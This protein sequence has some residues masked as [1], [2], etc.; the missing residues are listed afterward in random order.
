MPDALV[1]GAAYSLTSYLSWVVLVRYCRFRNSLERIADVGGF[2]FFG[3]LLIPVVSSFLTT[4]AIWVFT[5]DFCPDFV[6]LYSVRWLSDA[7]GVMVIAPFLLVWYS[8]TRINWR[9]EQTLEVLIWLFVLIFLGA[10]VFRNWAPTDTLRYP[11]ELA[12]FPI[13]A[14]AAIRFGQRGVTL[15]ILLA[16]MMAVWELRDVIGP[17]A[18]KTISQPPGYL[19]VFV[20]VL[21]V[22]SLFLAATWTELRK[23]EDELRTNEERLRAFVHAMPD[24]ALVFQEDGTCS[25]IFAPINSHFRERI[26]SFKNEPLESIYPPDL[27]RKFRDTIQE[28]VQK[29]DLAIVRYAISVDGMDRIYEGRFAPIEAFGEQQ[30]AVMVVSYDLTDNQHARQDLQKRD[31]LLKT[32]TE[33]EGI[34]LKEKIFHRGVRRAIECIGKGV[35][36]DMVQVYRVHVPTGTNDIMECTHEWLREN[37]YMFG[38]TNISEESLAQVSPRWKEIFEEGKPWEMHYSEADES[39]RSFMNSLG[40]RSITLMGITPTGGELGFIIFGSSLERSGKD[41]HAFAVL[42]AITESLRAYMENQLNQEELNRT[43]EAAIAADHAK[44]EFLAIMSHEIRTPMNAIIGFSDLL[45]QT[46]MSEQQKEYVDIILRSGNDLLDLINNILDFSRLESNSI[47][48][49]RTRFSL[50][51]AI[52]E[53]MEMVLFKAK[54]KGIGLTYS[55]LGIEKSL[56]WG[57]P[58]RL[59]QILLNL[60]TNAVKFT[61]EGFVRLEVKIV[62]TEEPWYTLEFSVLDT[63]IGIPEEN[64]TELF[65]AFRQ[66]D[67]STTRE[68]GGTGLGLSIVQRL[69]DKMGGRVSME[70]TVG[71]GSTF[72]VVVRLERDMSDEKQVPA[73]RRKPALDKS[74]AGKHPLT[75][76][77]VEDD[78]VNTRL[79]CE[80]LERLGYPVEA[81]T[82][83]FKALAVLAE[84]RHNLVMMDMQMA[85]L[86]GLE[87]TLRIRSGECGDSVQGISII[88]LTALALPEE[89]ERILKSGVDHYLSK[90]IGL[91]ALKEILVNVSAKI[92]GH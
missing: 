47:E 71:K 34:L 12:M 33:A 81:V 39:T 36:L 5:P 62:E 73:P 41:N 68:Y 54:E 85:R 72:F 7:L 64:R 32:L 42:M 69:V 76:L 23:R 49:E 15:G 75:I 45:Q 60:L 28:V 53:S 1:F 61:H 26:S 3:V 92:S 14:W 38:S 19:W 43:K 77:V 48:L 40:M 67:S 10:L 86:D 91:A 18:I 65:K 22:T 74:F 56:F 87:T 46:E 59:R 9:N 82:D 83:G 55:G 30:A 29:R 50:E 44:S 88:A 31:M 25:E 6:A 89:R 79:I 58:L 63:G 8:R 17:D 84:G 11:M 13:M 66:S 70:S 20:G 78:L 24:L 37:P 90:P 52:M 51:T 27:A 16:S 57:D 80:I 35:S 4:S 2:L 21:S